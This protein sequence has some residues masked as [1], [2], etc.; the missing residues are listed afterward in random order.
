M[1][2]VSG[3]WGLEGRKVNT[4]LR[5]SS[6]HSRTS[7]RSSITNTPIIVIVGDIVVNN[8]QRTQSVIWT[9]YSRN[10]LNRVTMED[11]THS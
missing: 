5:T 2:L 10:T 4:Y 3:V 9:Q 1:S 7:I 6:P 11:Y 8:S